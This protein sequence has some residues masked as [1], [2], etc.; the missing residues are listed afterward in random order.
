MAIV[1]IKWLIWKKCIDDAYFYYAF[2]F[3]MAI[4]HVIITHIKVISFL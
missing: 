4:T 3:Y 2:Y 1:L